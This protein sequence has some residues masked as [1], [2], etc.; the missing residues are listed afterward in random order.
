M[1]LAGLEL[2][3]GRAHPIPDLVLRPGPLEVCD[4]GGDVVER[5]AVGI[6]AAQHFHPTDTGRFTAR[7]KGFWPFAV[8]V[9]VIC[10]QLRV[11]ASKDCRACSAASGPASAPPDFCVRPPLN[12]R[13][14]RIPT[15]TA[16]PRS[17][18]GSSVSRVRSRTRRPPLPRRPA[19]ASWSRDSIRCLPDRQAL[20]PGR[21]RRA[22]GAARPGVAYAWADVRP[23]IR[24]LSTIDRWF[25]CPGRVSRCSGRSRPRCA[26]CRSF[27][28]AER[29][30][31]R[32][33]AGEAGWPGRTRVVR[34]GRS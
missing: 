21:R 18:T 1:R 22:A 11:V 10:G 6:E 13:S 20:G 17:A 33:T 31:R 2:G 30:A 19:R 3:G 27:F 5:G 4:G 12:S 7:G 25:P 34:R 29:Q 28:G 24:C 26:G 23:T 8:T 16:L 14:L 15:P 32:R 9:K